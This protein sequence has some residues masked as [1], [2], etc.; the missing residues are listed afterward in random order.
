MNTFTNESP[1]H[2]TLIK[3]TH[4]A[5]Q[6]FHQSEEAKEQSI[7]IARQLD[8]ALLSSGFKATK[9]LLEYIGNLDRAY[10][11]ITAKDI[12][13]A[14][15]QLKG[16][17]VQHN[18]YFKEFPKNIPDTLEFWAELLQN[19]LENGNG[20]K[21]EYGIGGLNLLSLDGYGKAQHSYEEMLA[22][23][24]KFIESLDDDICL[25]RL[26]DTLPVEAHKL[27][28]SLAES[29]V[30]ANGDDL[31]L[32]EQLAESTLDMAQPKKIGVRENRA[33][34]NSVR[35]RN[36]RP[37]LV[38]TVTDIL[39]LAVYLSGG[40]V[41]LQEKT[42]FRKFKASE[43]TVIMNALE[44][45]IADNKGKLGDVFKNRGEFNILAQKLHIKDY[46]E[47]KNAQEVFRVARERIN[48]SF[49]AKAE[50]AFA[51]KD[52]EALIALFEKAPGLFIKSFNRILL[53]TNLAGISSVVETLQ[54]V[55][56][57][58]ETPTLIGLRQYLDNRV[59]PKTNRIFMNRKGTGR[60]EKDTQPL[61]SELVVNP[62]REIIDKEVAGRLEGGV[63]IVNRDILNVALPLSN[64]ATNSG[65]GIMPRGSV[66]SF[67]GEIL[68]FFN[69]WKQ[70][71]SRTDYDLSAILLDENFLSVG[72]L[73]YTNLRLA[74]GVHSGDITSAPNGASEFI[75]IEWAKVN[76]KYIIPQVNNFSGEDFDT[77]KESFFGYMSRTEAQKGKPFEARTVK[78]KAEMRGKNK[79]ALPLVFIKEDDGTL[80]VKWI[81]ANL[82]GHFAGNQTENNTLSTTTMIRAIVENKY[83]TVQ[84]LVDL[85]ASKDDVTLIYSDE[86]IDNGKIDED[87]GS[88]IT[89]IG[90]SALESLP[91]SAT[92]INLTNLHELL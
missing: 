87:L 26:G 63:Y 10:A 54:K 20:H 19:T 71:R 55:A 32:L 23:H 58:V 75:D 16:D 46:R 35:L 72:Q 43:R 31:V 4:R 60:V 89:Y 2:T 51:D 33:V 65:Y 57:K 74:N 56:P 24:E 81:N 67:E 22:A 68:R 80:S 36:R 8:I 17:H 50:K 59:E 15:K 66:D 49:E 85:L 21:I 42:K 79:V 83:L 40:D 29:K 37:I 88:S 90:K 13:D 41:S 39:R 34:I 70:K 27:Y 61:L 28:L 3:R 73:S 69:Y 76:A 1:L 82:K 25:I 44:N 84:Y 77:V 78:S 7:T 14:V 62:V 86:L 47:L 52:H 91:K 5:P 48:L 11:L 6:L 45:I 18:T 53:Q 9:E 30:V 12:I 92:V 38:D 64:K